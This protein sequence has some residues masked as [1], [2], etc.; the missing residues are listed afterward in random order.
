MKLVLVLLLFVQKLSAAELF[1]V[2]VV[3]PGDTLWGIANKYL[4]DPTRWDEILRHNALPTSDPT[5]ALPGL[6]LKVP[7]ILIKEQ[8]RA[9]KLISILNEVLYRR[10]ET[11]DW[12]SAV[13]QMDLYEEDSLR[14]MVEAWAKVLYAKGEV[15]SLHPNSVAV[16]KPPRKNVELELLRGEIRAGSSRVLT[17]SALITPKTK[18]TDYSAKVKEDL[19]TLVQ[20]YSGRAAVEA[21][22]Q[23]VEVPAGFGSEVQLERPPSKPIPLPPLAEVRSSPS[24]RFKGSSGPWIKFTGGVI[25][26]E[27]VQATLGKEA[28]SPA[29]QDPSITSKGNALEAEQA[30]AKALQVGI[31][32]QGYHAQL[33]KDRN[34]N[35]IILDRMYSFLDRMDLSRER[36]PMGTYWTRV[37][38]VDLLGLEGRFSAPMRYEVTGTPPSLVVSRPSPGER[39]GV[40]WVQVEGVA[41]PMS[42]V[43]VNGKEVAVDGGG[44]FNVSIH[45][46][47]GY[48][49]IRL[50]AMN[51]SGLETKVTRGVQY[52]LAQAPQ[53]SE[54][55]AGAW[56][57]FFESIGGGFGLTLLISGLV[58]VG[59]VLIVLAL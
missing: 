20:V 19:T 27:G 3:Q 15:L 54:T 22:G 4:K 59:V 50:A 41:T 2:I 43:K 13:L 57:G 23:V 9:A 18:N 58:I 46:N 11:P 12:R 40:E 38:I 1:Q 25:S 28:S 32:I 53:K 44:N 29:D 8:F 49:E 17:A 30:K 24:D 34:F 37:A 56:Q 10:K 52:S 31:P 39:V 45:L 47:P 33:A 16:L 26:V 5:V 6:N 51:E 36:L 35:Q 55:E 7:V 48:N 14:T 42:V 21:Q